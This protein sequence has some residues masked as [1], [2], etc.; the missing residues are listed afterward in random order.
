MAQQTPA[1][2]IGL[3]PH[4]AE[5]LADANAGKRVQ[6][7][8]TDDTLREGTLRPVQT[9]ASEHPSETLVR[10]NLGVTEAE[11]PLLGLADARR[12]GRYRTVQ[13]QG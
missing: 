8:D 9:P 11:V 5:V 1:L 13:A 2:T 7:A 10:V 12:E 3:I 4:I 6:Y